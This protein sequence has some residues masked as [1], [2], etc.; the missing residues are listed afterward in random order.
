LGPGQFFNFQWSCLNS[1]NFIQ[2]GDFSRADQKWFFTLSYASGPG[3][4][5]HVNSDG[6]RKSPRGKSYLS[7][8][9]RQPTTVADDDETH[10]GEDVGVFANGPY[11]HVINNDWLMNYVS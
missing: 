4:Y 6:T 1:I 9:F 5:D 11:A 8:D 7:P 2:P 3:H 10:A